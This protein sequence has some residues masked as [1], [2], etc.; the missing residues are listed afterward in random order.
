M[1][2]YSQHQGVSLYAFRPDSDSH[3]ARPVYG[4]DGKFHGGGWGWHLDAEGS[5]WSSDAGGDKIQRWRLQG[6]DDD[7][8]PI[9]DRE[10]PE[11][12][13]RPEG[14]SGLER[15]YYE[16]GTDTLYLS[17]TTPEFPGIGWGLAGR[18]IQR[19][20]NWTRGD[21]S[22]RFT[23]KDLPLDNQGRPPKSITVAGDY[24]FVGACWHSGGGSPSDGQ[25]PL[26]VY[27]YRTDSGEYVGHM[28]VPWKPQ[29]ILDT[30]QAINAFRRA[31]GQYMIIVE[32][33]YRGKNIV[34][35]WNP[36][37]ARP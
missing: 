5:L 32:E 37:E 19:Y 26:M 8:M 7:G 31:N 23:I 15:I 21:T 9:Y 6:W 20:D 25:K 28:W 27:V 4:E 33:V 14:W 3:I 30:R 18:V 13:P 24:I 22:L 35:L 34:Y 2:Y 29:G 12:W 11:E 17:G 16:T 1:A 36:P 10:N